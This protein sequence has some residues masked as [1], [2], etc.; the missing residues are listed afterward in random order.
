MAPE[1]LRRILESYAELINTPRI[2]TYENYMWSSYQL[3]LAEPQRVGEEQSLGLTNGRFGDCH[4]DGGDSPTHLSCGTV[5]SDLPSEEGWEPGRMHFV[6]VGCYTILSPFK[7]FFFTG[8]QLHGSTRPTVPDSFKI[9]QWAC[10]AMLISYP[11]K[12]FALGKVRHCFGVMPG[13]KTKTFYLPPD[14]YGGIH[15]P[16]PDGYYTSHTSTAQDGPTVMDDA[17]LLNFHARGLLSWAHWTME[18]LPSRLQ[19][20]IDAEKFLSAFT[21][22]DGTKG[23]IGLKPWSMAPSSS[24]NEPYE[25]RHVDTQVEMLHTL[26]DRMAKAIPALPPNTFESEYLTSRGK[27]IRPEGG[28]FFVTF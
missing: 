24:V 4:T 22:R 2:G 28:L 8:L 27:K 18:C 11:S 19:I 20:E 21:Y 26:Y 7:Q 1:S 12:A 14:V 15:T 9:P 25:D 3:N 13:K 6:G 23:R 16:P 10:R 17:S 5:L